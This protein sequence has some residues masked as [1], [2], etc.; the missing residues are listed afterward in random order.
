MLRRS[1]TSFGAAA[2]GFK[3]CIAHTNP[4]VGRAYDLHLA[5]GK[6]SYLWDADGVKYLDWCCGIGVTNLGHCHPQL[7]AACKQ[8]LDEAWHLQISFG[9]HV[10]MR[11]LIERLETIFPPQ[12]TNFHFVSTGAEAVEAALKLARAATGRQNTAVVQ[13]GYHGRTVGAVSLTTSKYGYARGLR[14]L[15]PGVVVCP[16]PYTSQLKL[17]ANTD[18]DTMVDRCLA[19]TEDVLHQ[20]THPSEV[21]MLIVEPTLGEGGYLPLPKRYY[22]GLRDICNKYGIL[23]CIDEVQTGYGRTGTN[24]NFE[25]LVERDASGAFKADQLPDIVTFAKGVANGL[26]LAGIVTKQELAAKQLPGQMGGTYS[27]NCIAVASAIEVV[28]VMAKEGILDNVNARGKQ[29]V[30]GL[31]QIVQEEKLPVQEVRGRGLMVALEFDARCPAG[32]S[33]DVSMKALKEGLMVLN[34]S[35]YETLRFIPAL[36]STA[37]EI[38][39]GLL[40]TRKALVAACS[41]V[42]DALKGPVKFQPCCPDSQKSCG[43]KSAC[44]HVAIPAP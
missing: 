17:P 4:G 29:L 24:F 31:K 8:Q 12:L 6:G 40:K 34:T 2:E 39:E 1:I 9:P 42:P 11:K 21:S 32:I 35:R 22:K 36:N 27:A 10:G 3:Y 41:L 15:M 14:P 5:K 43:L 26:P 33:G 23:L 18:V 28:D 7:V 38:E 19:M 44:R 25:Q 37:E 16:L 20:S 30:D 13:G